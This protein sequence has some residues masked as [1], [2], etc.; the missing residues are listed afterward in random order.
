MFCIKC[1]SQIIEGQAFC[2][3]CGTAVNLNENN[4]NEISYSQAPHE[5]MSMHCP[6]CGNTKLQA[7]ASNKI[8]S[9][10]TMGRRVGKKSAISNTAYN[11]ITETYWFCSNCG[12]KFRDLDELQM[13]ISQDKRAVKICQIF[14][15][16]SVI[17]CFLFGL[18]CS[19]LG[20]KHFIVLKFLLGLFAFLMLPTIGLLGLLTAHDAKVK[21]EGKR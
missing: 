17:A 11:S 18:I 21:E 8:A 12:M 16:V 7:V 9:S 13:I 3:N 20:D 5:R 15:I 14:L 4:Q 2:G 19:G 10:M 6:R 1:G